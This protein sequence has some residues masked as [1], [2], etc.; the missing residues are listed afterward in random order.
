MAKK[1]EKATEQDIEKKL[2]KEVQHDIDMELAKI[3][4]KV[5]NSERQ[6]E[7]ELKKLQKNEKDALRI[8]KED[9]KYL[10]S[11]APEQ[12]AE[13]LIGIHSRAVSNI[14]FSV[15]Q[16][17]L[18]GETAQDKYLIIQYQ[19]DLFM[20]LESRGITHIGQDIVD[21]LKEKNEVHLL[22]IFNVLGYF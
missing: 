4:Q 2:L 9:A 13:W 14:E 6:Q 18:D 15:S 7:K 21:I 22:C 17:F 8:I 20:F 1:K 12:F 3:P 10:E 16:M 5:L 19:L 11:C